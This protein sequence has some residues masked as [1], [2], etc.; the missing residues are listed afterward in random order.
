M[1]ED[2]D[3]T[4]LIGRE[5]QEIVDYFR[6]KGFE[7][8]FRWQDVWQDAHKRAFTVAGVTKADVLKTLRSSVTDALS[9]GKTLREFK[10]DLE[11]KLREL[12]WWGEREII[13]PET[14]EVR[15][16]EL[17]SPHRL[18]T[19]YR[20]N[21]QTSYMAGR[22]R[23][24]QDNIDRRPYWRYVAVLDP[25]T[26]PSHAERHG[27]VLR[28]DDPW[29]D[30][31]Y[32]PNG[33]GCRCRV[34]SLSERQVERRGLNVQDGS[35]VGDFADEEWRFNPADVDLEGQVGGRTYPGQL[36]SDLQQ[37]LDSYETP[38]PPDG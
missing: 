10:Q 14:G 27:T 23:S 33:W 25:S 26:R 4:A 1:A 20:T 5:P 17:G 34:Q 19:I 24:Q 21:L 37:E 31:H 29:W 12:G 9:E 8:S 38:D 28:A 11:P 13:D 32:P 22:F 35:D 7:I 2:V 16:T 6:S 30:E 3:L 15:T 36:A 18:R